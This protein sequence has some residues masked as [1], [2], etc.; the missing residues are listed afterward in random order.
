MTRRPR[1]ATTC[2]SSS[3]LSRNGRRY[4]VRVG[5]AV[6]AWLFSIQSCSDSVARRVAGETVCAGAVGEVVAP[7]GHELVDVGLVARVPQDHVA[8]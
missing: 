6:D 1:T 2:R 4:P 7:T 8:R 5:Q 3:P